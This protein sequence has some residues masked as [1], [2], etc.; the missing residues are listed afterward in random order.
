MAS[1]EYNGDF[2]FVKCPHGDKE[3]LKNVC[4]DYRWMS[5]TKRWR[6]PAQCLQNAK[7][8]LEV[9]SGTGTPA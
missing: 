5:E 4:P 6:T 3:I 9:G 7:A 8:A 1:F 2:A